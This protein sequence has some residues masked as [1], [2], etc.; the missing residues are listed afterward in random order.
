MGSCKGIC[1]YKIPNKKKPGG[2]GFYK[3][4]TFQI[5]KKCKQCEYIIITDEYKCE[6]CNNKYSKFSNPKP[7]I[8]L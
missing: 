2:L 8:R 6:C 4:K 3:E 5:V 1:E 7:L